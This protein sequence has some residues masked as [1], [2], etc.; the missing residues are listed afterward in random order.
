MS[1]VSQKG[2]LKFI[3]YRPTDKLDPG[4]K[5]VGHKLRWIAAT[6]TEDKMGRIWRVLRK[7]ELSKDALQSLS[8]SNRDMFGSGDTIRNRELVLSYASEE[9][10]L[11][12]RNAIN[13]SSKRQLSSVTSK[14]VP[15]GGRHMKVQESELSKVSTAEFFDN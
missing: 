12:E 7:S 15:G 4:F 11:V 6:Q 8:E 13:E 10:V 2:S 1:A 5:I 3:S 14:A 9:A